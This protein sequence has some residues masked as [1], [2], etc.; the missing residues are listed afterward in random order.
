MNGPQ[1]C[2]LQMLPKVENGHALRT[3]EVKL[4]VSRKM[5]QF[6]A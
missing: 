6:N 3:S 2:L 1:A 5:K 4:L